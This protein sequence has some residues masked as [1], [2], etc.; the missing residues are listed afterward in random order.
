MFVLKRQFIPSI[1]T[2]GQKMWRN[3]LIMAK[4]I[5][6]FGDFVHGVLVIDV[7]FN[8]GHKAAS[9]VWKRGV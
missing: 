7:L 2:D 6:R 8:C 1:S 9:F 3:P 4:F 5:E